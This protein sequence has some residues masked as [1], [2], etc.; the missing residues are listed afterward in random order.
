MLILTETRQILF[1]LT[2]EVDI[3]RIDL[4]RDEASRV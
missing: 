1:I 4:N 3:T 2:K